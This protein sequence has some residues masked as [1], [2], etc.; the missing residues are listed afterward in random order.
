MNFMTGLI[1]VVIGGI[2][3]VT[4]MLL[5]QMRMGDRLGPKLFPAVVGVIA[6]V[7]GIILMIQD[8]RKG[9]ASKKPDFGFVKNKN[10]WLKIL[11]TTVVGIAYGLVMDSLGFILPTTLFM[12]FISMLINKGRFVQNLI[13]ALCFALISYGVF[14]VALKLSLPRGFIEQMLPF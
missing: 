6:F 14:A 4:T 11:L 8:S 13:V 5:P 1:A 2:Y 7:S 9:K 12:L 3:L 10:L